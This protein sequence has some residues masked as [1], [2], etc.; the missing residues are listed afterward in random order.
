LC[1]DDF[2]KLTP[3]EFAAV[4]EQYVE[5]QQ[6][7]ERGEWERMRLLASICIQPHIKKKITAQKLLPLPWDN[8]KLGV[9]SEELGIKKAP[10]VSK[11]EALRR[12]QE[13]IKS[14]KDFKDIKDI[15]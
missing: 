12:L 15:K 4:C 13:R 2:C 8:E 9:K 7:R 10:P 3:A 1:F 11:E 14:V 6:Q 5:A